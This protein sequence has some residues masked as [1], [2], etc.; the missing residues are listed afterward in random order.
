MESFQD[1]CS[2]LIS[3]CFLYDATGTLDVP[4]VLGGFMITI[5]VLPLALTICL[6]SCQRSSIV[7]AKDDVEAAKNMEA[8]AETMCM[9]E[10]KVVPQTPKRSESNIEI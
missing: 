2:N 9:L 5:G 7:V 1:F 8:E 4:L 3:I 10:Q 6:S